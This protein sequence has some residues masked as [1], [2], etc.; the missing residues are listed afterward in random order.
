M[1]NEK[2]LKK[3]DPEIFDVVKGEANREHSTLELIA[4][5]VRGSVGRRFDKWGGL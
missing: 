4:F 3:V 2:I 1:N 5:V